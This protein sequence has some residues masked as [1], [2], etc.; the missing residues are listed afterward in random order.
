MVRP[1][2]EVPLALADAE[3]LDVGELE[4][5]MEPALP[6]AAPAPAPAPVPE[7]PAPVDPEAPVP[8]PASTPE[9]APAPE[10][11]VA[12][13]AAAPEAPVGVGVY[14]AMVVRSEKMGSWM[15]A[16]PS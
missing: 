5:E 9:S 14:G 3:V 13:V 11:P 8:E 15:P 4:R 12:P 16:R 7:D 1:A 2:S 6:A 10:A